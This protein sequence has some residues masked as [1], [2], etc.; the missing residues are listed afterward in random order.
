MVEGADEGGEQ[1]KHHPFGGWR[2]RSWG[3]LQ[4]RRRAAQAM[5][6]ELDRLYDVPLAFVKGEMVRNIYYPQCMS[7]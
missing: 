2:G 1:E 7:R 6:R 4:A 5:R 3:G